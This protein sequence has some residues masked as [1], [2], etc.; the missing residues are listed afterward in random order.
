MPR[1][2]TN[3]S[4][5]Q[6]QPPWGVAE[7]IYSF[8][9]GFVVVSGLLFA[10]FH[11]VFPNA[12]DFIRLITAHL[13]SYA[14][15]VAILIILIKRYGQETFFYLGLRWD[16]TWFSYL[17]DGFF[18]GGTILIMTLG[19][20]YLVQKFNIPYHQPFQ[21]FR[22]EH[23]QVIA[24]LAIVTAPLLEEIAFRGFLQSALYRY[25]KVGPA[26]V[27]TALLF[28][29]FHSLYYGNWLALIYVFLMGTCLGVFRFYAQSIIPCI[30]GHLINNVLAA[31]VILGF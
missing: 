27:L 31:L 25:M 26:I 29:A 14:V 18:C 30:I 1:N 22:K 4:S 28:T 16:K 19:F 8:L 13:A 15:W 2:L 6:E 12:S 24:A 7:V 23:M 9:L 21:D 10:L 11:Y 20:S 5:T 3:Y 17:Y